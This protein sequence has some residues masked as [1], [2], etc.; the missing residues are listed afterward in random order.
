MRHGCVAKVLFSQI[1]LASCVSFA[2]AAPCVAPPATPESIAEFKANPG[3][4]VAPNSDTRAIE[5][6][7]RE[8]AGTSADLAPDL[9]NL[10][11]GTTPRFRTAIAAGLAQAAV[12]CSTIDQ[13]AALQIQQAVA[14]FE[15]SQ[16]Q[17]SFAA[18]AGDMSTS[19]TIAAANTAT[20]NAG[21]VVIV[22]PNR[23]A[24]RTFNPGG[25]GRSAVVQITSG[26]I[27]ITADTP[28]AGT[29]TAADPVSPTR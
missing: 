23:A 24:S 12:A 25:G 28:D 13:Q 27:I 8:L 2:W 5:A 15:N 17:S 18:V 19:A 29:T 1:V 4:L 7:V 26:T 9:V 21:S 16:F 22:N 20:G 6:R 14:S 10:A 11:Q 3:A